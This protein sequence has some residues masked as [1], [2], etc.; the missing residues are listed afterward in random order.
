LRDPR[1]VVLSCYAQRF[2]M[3]AGMAQF[4][5]LESAANYYDAVMRLLGLCREKLALELIEV[6]YEDT[7]ADVAAQARALTDFLGLPFEDTMLW[8]RETAM[9]RGINTPSARQVIEPIYAR[10]VEKWRRYE[11]EL[12]PVLPLLGAWAEGF[13]YQ[14]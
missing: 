6:R 5:E 9:R 4:L 2:D 3:N 12:A 14:R 7:V 8:F 10:S 11:S 1:D 13:G